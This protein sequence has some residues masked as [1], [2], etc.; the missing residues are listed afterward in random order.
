M[1]KGRNDLHFSGKKSDYFTATLVTRNLVELFMTTEI[2]FPRIAG[3]G[4]I[5]SLGKWFLKVGYPK[6]TRF[7]SYGPCTS[8]KENEMLWEPLSILTVFCSLV[9]THTSE[10]AHGEEANNFVW[11]IQYI[12]FP[13]HEM[14]STI[15]FP[16]LS[17]WGLVSINKNERPSSSPLGIS[18]HSA[19]R[20]QSC[21]IA[22]THPELS[23]WCLVELDNIIY[24]WLHCMDIY[25]VIY[26][27]LRIL[28]YI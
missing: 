15:Q 7:H 14:L 2:G 23:F 4:T 19:S 21:N 24:I 22:C 11:Q 5:L 27:I 17:S 16:G 8:G 20:A 12:L 9:H 18:W 13:K 25:I 1:P 26:H 10:I 3:H 6:I 28:M